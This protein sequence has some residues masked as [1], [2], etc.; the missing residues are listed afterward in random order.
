MTVALTYSLKRQI[1]RKARMS[2]VFPQFLLVFFLLVV[3]KRKH[4]FKIHAFFGFSQF[5]KE[6]V[7]VPPSSLLVSN[8]VLHA[9]VV[10][11]NLVI[12]DIKYICMCSESCAC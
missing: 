9:H 10:L 2:L 5:R 7:G 11:Q 6:F 1:E 3:G 4:S 8:S 12:F